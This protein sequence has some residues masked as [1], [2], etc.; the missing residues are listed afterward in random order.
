ML[1]SCGVLVLVLLFGMALI[2][3][4]GTMCMVMSSSPQNQPEQGVQHP[5]PNFH[6]VLERIG[7][8][9]LRPGGSKSTKKLQRW[10]NLSQGDSVL[11]LSAGLGK[12]GIM[13][14]ED[15]ACK[16]LVTDIDENR[17]GEAAAAIKLKRLENLINTKK[18]D[19][20]RLEGGIGEEK[21]FDCTMTEASLTHFP[22]KKKLQVLKGVSKHSSQFLLHE[23]C[24]KHEDVDIAANVKK[25]MEKV[26]GIGFF[27]ETVDAWRNILKESGFPVEREFE[28]GD[29]ALLD[30]ANILIDEGPLVCTKIL[31]NIITQPYLRSRILST[32]KYILAHKESL[33]YIIMRATKKL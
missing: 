28:V 16:V 27:P 10:A 32:R 9:V 18:V 30:L 4:K 6:K 24:L 2:F 21:K 3:P 8:T 15:Y 20:F 1:D 14:A 25:D 23:I 5:E 13:F 29:L 26:L 22:R 7:K 33:G 31:R 11:E 12:S 19:M 17:L